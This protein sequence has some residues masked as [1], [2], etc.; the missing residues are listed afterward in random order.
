MI[1][2]V[3][4]FGVYTMTVD[5]IYAVTEMFVHVLG[6]SG[7]LHHLVAVYKYYNIMT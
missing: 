2:I 7:D 4:I 1:Y 5:W 3:I 6:E